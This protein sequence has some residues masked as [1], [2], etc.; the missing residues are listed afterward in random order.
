[1]TAGFVFF[2]Y[3]FVFVMVFFL[4]NYISTPF[5]LIVL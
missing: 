2:I 5:S 3:K 4:D 1:M